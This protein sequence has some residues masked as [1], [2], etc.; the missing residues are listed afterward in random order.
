MLKGI[1]YFIQPAELV[2]TDRYKIGCSKSPDLKRCNEGYRKGS[3]Y[4][5]IMECNNPFVLEKK[6]KDEFNKLFKLVAGTEYFIGDETMMKQTFLK[7]IEK[8]D[9]SSESIIFDELETSDFDNKSSY[10]ITTYEDFLLTSDIKKIIVINKKLKYGYLKFN[11]SSSRWYEIND[12]EDLLGWIV[13]NNNKYTLCIDKKTNTLCRLD[14]SKPE[15]NMRYK[16][17]EC[18][19]DFDK[20]C[21]DIYVKCYHKDI[22][23]HEIL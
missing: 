13:N 1:I 20:I 15:K 19:Y 16:I 2:G 8:Y 5:C 21:D 12:Q 17:I 14:E 6:I 9:N 23:L 3:R 7:I 18:N 11:D 22:K 10:D 4:I